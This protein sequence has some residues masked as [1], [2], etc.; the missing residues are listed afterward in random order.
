MIHTQNRF[1]KFEEKSLSMHRLKHKYLGA[2]S[3]PNFDFSLI[4]RES[5]IASNH[6]MSHLQSG[7]PHGIII[8][9]RRGL[10]IEFRAKNSAT[11]STLKTILNGD[12]LCTAAALIFLFM[13]SNKKYSHSTSPSQLIVLV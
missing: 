7:Y 1:L 11:E 2:L 4:L 6:C 9:P 3:V 13:K 10:F 8:D 5:L 12:R